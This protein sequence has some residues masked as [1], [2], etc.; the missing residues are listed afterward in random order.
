MTTFVRRA[1]FFTGLLLVIWVTLRVFGA[2]PPTVPAGTAT[3]Y[4]TFCGAG[5]AA[6]WGLYKYLR[7]NRHD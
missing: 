4:A 2:D 5:L 6:I 1:T 3:A 7:E